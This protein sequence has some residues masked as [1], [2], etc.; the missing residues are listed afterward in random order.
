MNSRLR[1]L[2]RCP[3][4]TFSE[5]VTDQVVEGGFLVLGACPRCDHRWTGAVPR[6]G[7]P[8]AVRPA[9]PLRREQGIAAA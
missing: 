5:V 1:T 7:F 8:R 4:C 9:A 2:Q 6:P 3:V